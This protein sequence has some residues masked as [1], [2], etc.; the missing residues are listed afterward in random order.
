MNTSISGSVL[1]RHLESEFD[2]YKAT[3]TI[4]YVKELI[5]KDRVDARRLGLNSL[6]LLTD[7][8]RSSISQFAT[9]AVLHED[10]NG[11]TTIKDFVSTLID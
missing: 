8:E 1:H 3:S 9:K 5:Q 2:H 7:C 10:E 11:D 6:L 4:E